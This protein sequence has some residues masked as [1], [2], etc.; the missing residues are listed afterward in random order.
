MNKLFVEVF[1]SIRWISGTI[2]GVIVKIFQ[3]LKL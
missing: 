2:F 1:K 3:G